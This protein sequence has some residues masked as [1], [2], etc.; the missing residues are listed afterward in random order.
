[1]NAGTA[2]G[3][4]AKEREPL[5]IVVLDDKGG[6]FHGVTGERLDMIT[7]NEEYDDLMKQP[8]VKFGTKLKLREFRELLDYLPRSSSVGVISANSFQQELFTESGAGTLIRRGHK[9]YKHGSTDTVGAH[10]IRQ[11][12]PDRDPDVV[13]GLARVTGVLAALVKTPYTLYGDEPTECIA[14][15]T[16]PPGETPVTTKPLPSRQAVSRGRAQDRV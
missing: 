11:I 13:A 10:R 1:V 14:I 2:A 16:H 3:E 8:W 9:L 7:L 15:V 6:L 4:L 5:E 12:V